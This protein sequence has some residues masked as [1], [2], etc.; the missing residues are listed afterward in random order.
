MRAGRFSKIPDSRCRL[1]LERVPRAN[2]YRS[3]SPFDT[4]GALCLIHSVWRGR[5]AGLLARLFT[6]ALEIL[7]GSSRGSAAC[8]TAN[9]A[10]ILYVA[11]HG[12]AGTAGKIVARG[13]W[14][15]AGVYVCRLG[16]RVG[17]IQFAICRAAV[18]CFVRDRG[19]Q[20]ARCLRGIGCRTHTHISPRDSALVRSRNHYRAGA[21]LRAH[22][23]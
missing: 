21:E 17:A 10:G 8:P 18:D 23:G 20:A 22:A 3:A 7:V 14:A 12:A 4:F 5:A 1:L 13:I 6:M 15:R 9:R 11:R 16:D 2:E 19:S